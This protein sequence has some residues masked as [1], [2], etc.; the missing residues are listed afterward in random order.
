MPFTGG[1]DSNGL[2][3]LIQRYFLEGRFGPMCESTILELAVGKHYCVREELSAQTS[4]NRPTP[5]AWRLVASS[6]APVYA[7]LFS[8]TWIT[9][10]RSGADIQIRKGTDRTLPLLQKK[11]H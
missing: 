10:Q 9:E 4:P 11:H 2:G 1:E 5:R 6:G 8:G 3:T 7:G